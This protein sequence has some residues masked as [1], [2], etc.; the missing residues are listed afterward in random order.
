LLFMLF[1][2][3]AAT[4]MPSC[5]QIS[6][7]LL[8]SAHETVTKWLKAMLQDEYAILASDGW[9]DELRDSV[10]SVNL[11]VRGKVSF[12]V[13][14][15]CTK[16]SLTFH[17]IKTYL[18]DLILATSHKKYGELMCNPFEGMINK[19]KDKYRV[20]IVA[21]CYDNNGGSQRER[22]ILVMKQPW[23]FEPPCY[24]HQV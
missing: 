8:D 16:C 1:Q 10:N 21:F 20:T 13:Y 11:S 17:F 19:A 5:Q 18:I 2:S 15:K 12:L 9:K 23:L 7:Q 24:T 6:S 4:V 14:S 3:T 22:K